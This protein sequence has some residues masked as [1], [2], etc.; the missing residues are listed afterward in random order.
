MKNLTKRSF[1]STSTKTVPI[2]PLTPFTNLPIIYSAKLPLPL[3]IFPLSQTLSHQNITYPYIYNTTKSF[4]ITQNLTPF[5]FSFPFLFNI[6]YSTLQL[7]PLLPLS[8]FSITTTT[9]PYY[10]FHFTFYYPFL[11]LIPY[12]IFKYTHYIIT[13]LLT[14][15]IK[16]LSSSFI[17][18]GGAFTL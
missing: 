18:G 9:N 2:N 16:H 14:L 7:F 3:L 5:S 13:S 15:L 10:H 6:L 4:T 17:W 1:F 8:L 12:F 11:I